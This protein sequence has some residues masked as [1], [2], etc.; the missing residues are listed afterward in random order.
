[1]CLIKKKS[2]LLKGYS[3]GE[4]TLRLLTILGANTIYMLG[5]DMAL[6]QETGATHIGDHDQVKVQSITENQK[7][8]NFFMKDNNSQ[9]KET[10]LVVKG[11][12]R[13][14]VVTTTAFINSINAYKYNMQIILQQNP[15]I[16]IFNLCDGAYLEGITPLKI[17]NAIIP[18]ENKQE[19]N[20]QKELLNHATMGVNTEDI[21]NIKECI[22]IVNTL[23]SNIKKFK[24]I[25]L[26][27]YQEFRDKRR[28]IL[29]IIHQ[30]LSSYAD[31]Y[32][33]IIFNRY[34]LTMEAY[35]G[36]QFNAKLTNEKEL[37]NRV[38]I[39]WCDHMLRL[40]SEYKIHM[41]KLIH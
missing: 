6:D 40:A 21:Q 25:K 41:S 29:T 5:T 19:L 36:F 31:L 24:K 2:E 4:I 26:K 12:F 34:Y 1:M 7:E 28:Q 18:N 27:S 30:H 11:N 14:T 39:V 33:G 32:A 20:I 13:D 35:L 8:E 38:K 37:I 15:N 10:S 17:E 9:T 23:I 22:V 3:V 16:K